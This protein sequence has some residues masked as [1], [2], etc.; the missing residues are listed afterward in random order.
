MTPLTEKIRSFWRRPLD[1]DNFQDNLC[2][3]PD[4]AWRLGE[5][6]TWNWIYNKMLKLRDILTIYNQTIYN[7]RYIDNI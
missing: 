1:W 7:Q 2:L 6:D 4:R 3:T 5:Q